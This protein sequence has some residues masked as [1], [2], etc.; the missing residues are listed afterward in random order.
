M[1]S[2]KDLARSVL[3]LGDDAVD[4]YKPIVNDLITSN[5]KDVNKIEVTLDYMLGFCFHKDM[6]LLYRKLCRHLYGIDQNAAAFYVNHYR[7]MF[8]EDSTQKF[9][10]IE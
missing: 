7:E 3:K 4:I 6:L 2:I 1:D 10:P 8:D 9:E 5:C